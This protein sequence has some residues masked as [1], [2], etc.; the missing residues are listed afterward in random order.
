LWS[1]LLVPTLGRAEVV[2]QALSS[3]IE[4]GTRATQKITVAQPDGIRFASHDDKA[5]TWHYGLGVAAAAYAAIGSGTP[6]HVKV[7]NNSLSL[8]MPGSASPI[9]IGSLSGEELGVLAETARKGGAP[10]GAGGK[11]LLTTESNMAAGLLP[12]AAILIKHFD[13]NV[14][15]KTYG[16]KSVRVFES[17]GSPVYL[18]PVRRGLAVRL[19]DASIPDPIKELFSVRLRKNEI[20]ML[21]MFSNG[22]P[23]SLARLLQVGRDRVARISENIS[24]PEQ[25]SLAG[26]ED[27]VAIL[28]GHVENG[29]FVLNPTTLEGHALSI[30]FAKIEEEAARTNTTVVYVGCE[31]FNDITGTGYLEKIRDTEILPALKKALDADTYLDLLSSLGTVKN[32]FILDPKHLKGEAGRV[33]IENQRLHENEAL[34]DGGATTVRIGLASRRGTPIEPI[35]VTSFITYLYWLG[36]CLSIF[37]F[38]RSWKSYAQV[39]PSL[40]NPVLYPVKFALGNSFKFILFIILLPVSVLTVAMMLLIVGRWSQREQ[41]L[42]LFWSIIV[43]PEMFYRSSLSWISRI[44]TCVFFLMSGTTV[45]FFGRTI[46]SMADRYMNSPSASVGIR[47]LLVL[48]AVGLEYMVIQPANGAENRIPRSAMQVAQLAVPITMVTIVLAAIVTP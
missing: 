20:K 34:V 29:A 35:D 21:A 9:D 40:P 32:P 47:A 48:A 28:V 36:A 10:T 1:L 16:A 15:D 26:F 4:D 14:F 3:S 27:G 33:T 19:Q 17:K 25:F 30:S 2:Q 18:V 41:I 31:S 13:L 7:D 39:F 46:L 12:R 11:P 37:A 38:R 42:D 44:G 45:I 24:A 23:D 8:F 5:P 22:D 6:P 43:K